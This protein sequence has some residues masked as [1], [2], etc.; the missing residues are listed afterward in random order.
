MIQEMVS[1]DAVLYYEDIAIEAE[2]MVLADIDISQ[3]RGYEG[4]E[5]FSED[6]ELFL[7]T[8][9]VRQ[10]FGIRTTDLVYITVHSFQNLM[11][12]LKQSR[13]LAEW[14]DDIELDVSEAPE[15]E[16]PIIVKEQF[17]QDILPVH[18][19]AVFECQPI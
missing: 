11:M 1:R 14:S 15:S 19:K 12:K 16:Y 18:G 3:C 9:Y 17:Y 6:L 8:S 10:V 2:I 5:D 4:D 7:T 13:N